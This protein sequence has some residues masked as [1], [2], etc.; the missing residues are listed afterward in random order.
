MAKCSVT[1]KS[2][3]FGNTVSHSH[4]RGNKMWKPNLKKVRIKTAG[5]NTKRVWVSTSAVRSGLVERA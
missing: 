5:G 2:V 4:R 3:L 1:G